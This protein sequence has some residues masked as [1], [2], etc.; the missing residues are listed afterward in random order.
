M[1]EK[2]R[3]AAITGPK[4]IKFLE[5]NRPNPLPG[6][7]LV[8]IHS[9][10]ICTSELRVWNGTTKSAWG[11]PVVLGHEA[12]GEV[13]EVGA[14]C[15]QGFT[16]GDKVIMGVMSDC[17]SCYQCRRGWNAK[18]AHSN[19]IYS[20][21]YP[22]YE[23]IGGG[24]GFSEYRVVNENELFTVSHDIPYEEAALGEPLSCVI[25]SMRK[26]D[27]K[28]GDDMVIIGA[29]PMG[30]MNLLVANR[31]GARTIVSELQPNRLKKAV[32]NG[33]I[34]IIQ[35]DIEDPIAKVK[36]LTGGRGA[37]FVVAA[38]GNKHVNDQAFEML[39]YGGR[40]VLFAAQH[41]VSP[42]ELNPNTIHSREVIISGTAGKDPDDL[43]I[44]AKL[45]STKMINV[46]SIIEKILPFEKINE[47]FELAQQPDTYRVV[48]QID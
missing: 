1:A 12:A 28:L 32:S 11:Y 34:D 25:H 22:Q 48:I 31:I 30:M 44:A 42:L 35:P 46:N 7:V 16:P 2:M 23:N 45:L 40:M 19:D 10:A 26:L 47:G 36:E 8:K 3:M 39:D 18:C 24:W 21:Y 6:Q 29:G 41:P 14:G 4:V 43:R 33:A 5:V 13:V 15:L 17:G 20:K 37:N 9:C 38:I 27:V